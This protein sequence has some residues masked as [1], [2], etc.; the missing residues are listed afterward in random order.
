VSHL[1][2][3]RHPIRFGVLVGVLLLL[4]IL[5]VV[6]TTPAPGPQ[7][8]GPPPV[9]SPQFE[10]LQVADGIAYLLTGTTLSALQA[11]TGRLLWQF[12]GNLVEN[13]GYTN[14]PALANGMVYL[15]VNNTSGSTSE[16]GEWLYALRGTDGKLLWR[17]RVSATFPQILPPG[18]QVIDSV[19]F[20]QTAG[21][22]YGATLFVL[23][24]S[25]GRLLWS[26]APGSDQESPTLLSVTDG[27]AYLSTHD[28]D[29]GY[30]QARQVSTGH[31]LW[32]YRVPACTIVQFY[33][34][35]GVVYMSD[36][37]ACAANLNGWGSAYALGARDGKLLWSFTPGGL[38]MVTDEF[39]AVDDTGSSWPGSDT[40][41]VLQANTGQPLW[42]LSANKGV[43]D[44]GIQV[45]AVDGTS[46]YTTINQQFFAFAAL[47]GQRRWNFPSANQEL[48]PVLPIRLSFST[49]LWLL[50]YFDATQQ[51]PVLAAVQATTGA[52]QW[53]R[54]LSERTIRWEA[55]LLTDGYITLR[56]GDQAN[57]VET[58]SVSDGTPLWTY[59]Q[60]GRLIDLGFFGGIAYVTGNPITSMLLNAPQTPPVLTALQA[61]DGHALWTF[62]APA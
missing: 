62:Q 28:A 14:P 50:P 59:Q 29:A 45:Q 37:G 33:L 41:Y 43:A 23:R 8:E 44:T 17:F 24:A 2:I 54:A 53:S 22:T 35:Q 34:R 51:K 32:Q 25:D 26:Q 46:V 30:L 15:N 47:T 42:H 4:C 13:L 38:L 40:L 31:L 3:A 55:L 5:F 27:I 56:S 19:V 20:A 16:R 11:T 21:Q 7:D 61:S 9:A 39:I 60:P 18:P 58:F 48:E 57:Q 10:G 36:V 49:G 52:L 1:E 12:R 6:W